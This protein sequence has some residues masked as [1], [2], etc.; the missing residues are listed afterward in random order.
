[1][2][3]KAR[4]LL[5]WFGKSLRPVATTAAYLLRDLGKNFRV[6]VGQGEHDRLIVHQLQVRFIDLGG[7]NAYEDVGAP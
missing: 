1:M 2:P 5:I 7:G 3:G 6:R 4:T